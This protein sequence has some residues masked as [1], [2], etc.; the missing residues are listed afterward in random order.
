MGRDEFPERSRVASVLH[1]WSWGV[2]LLLAVGSAPSDSA[3]QAALV[4]LDTL[5]VQVGSRAN[6]RL[7]S[8][9]RTV[10]LFDHHQI[11]SLPVRTLSGLLAWATGVEIQARSPAQSDIGIRGGGFEQVVVLV[12]GVRMSDPQ[13]GHF[14]LDLAVP[15]DQIDRVEVL[16]GPASALYG[17]DAVGG[18]VNVVTKDAAQGWSGRIEG[19]SWGSARM[20]LAAGALGPLGTDV[21]VGGE[22]SRS[23]GH[24]AGTDHEA[25]LVHASLHRPVNHGAFSA[26]LG[27]GRRDFGARD[28]YAP[29]PS[30]EKTRTY[31]SALRWSSAEGRRPGI[32]LG[33]SFRRHEDEF[34]L[35]RDDPAVY[36]NRH[37]SSQAGG[38][39]I[40][41]RE[42]A[43][44][45]SVV[46]GGELFRDLLRSNSL[47]DRG[48][49]RGAFY[50]EG[51]LG[52]GAPGILSVGFRQDWH[53][54]F[55]SF[56]SPSLSGA[57]R[58]GAAAK[59]RGALGRS[60]R[61]PTW[62]ERYYNDPVNRG[63]ADLAPE[64]AWSAE[65]GFDIAPGGG[66]VFGL[67]AFRRAATE[68]IDWARPN[69]AAGDGS[70]V[71]P[72]W[73]T[74]NVEEATFHGIE[75]EASGPAPFGLQWRFG[76]MWL[77][78]DAG[79]IEGF[80]SKY[81]L[82]PL[83]SQVS[84]GLERS[85]TGRGTVGLNVH[86]ARRTGEEAYLRVDLRARV[87]TG[88]V[89]VYLDATNLL[90][91]EYPD[92]TGALAPGRA[93]FMGI[94]IGPGSGRAG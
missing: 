44:G 27:I 63:R 93:V 46:A 19:G 73:E 23:D 61:A 4:P 51:V 85:V 24:R 45:L 42:L 15:L 80:T 54:G 67:T 33:F 84:A 79:E 75:T 90:G 22:F 55:G 48:E 56:F 2:A 83:T 16:R 7:P 64:K 68:L 20:S 10:Q 50:L 18:V 53:Q 38:D 9:T 3:A 8:L 69:P 43:A 70:Q 87:R 59:I 57:L 30:Y 58:F 81:A 47:G 89:W 92:I 6:A 82:R 65:V 71:P 78:V 62:T 49:T 35:I 29:Y 91:E 39:A 66:V 52:N 32:E 41:R 76:G 1:R 14:D 11:A 17:A 77:S 21:R 25:T 74:R 88:G 36:Q 60:F 26:E 34:T 13:T 31:T 40:V 86:R 94:E 72:P 5:H 12:N 28:F 37:S